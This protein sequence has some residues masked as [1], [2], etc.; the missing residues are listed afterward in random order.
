MMSEP[1]LNDYCERESCLTTIDLLWTG[2]WDSTFRLLHL[3]LVEKSR[4]KPYYVIDTERDSTLFELRAME[5]VRAWLLEKH[6][7]NSRMLLPT[8]LVLKADIPPNDTI[9]NRYQSL[10][11]S[12][13]I[14]VQYEWLA[15][16]ANTFELYDLELC[17]ERFPPE[18]V[19]ELQSLMLS[20]LQGEGHDCRMQDNLEVDALSMFHYFRF[21]TIHLTKLDMER[22]SRQYGFRDVLQHTWFCH[23]PTQSGLPCGECRP[24]RL[25]KES[26]LRR[27]PAREGHIERALMKVAKLP[28]RLRRLVTEA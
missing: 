10:A 18:Q 8:G 22:L 20:S 12:V 4:V 19:N 2:G 14:G 17:I 16:F 25:V 3:L 13:Y 15:R 5:N 1:L 23:S 6:P 11:S 21:P 7:G 24:C 9:T 27:Q 28:K 26:G